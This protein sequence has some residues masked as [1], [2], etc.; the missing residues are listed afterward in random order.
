MS[1]ED[2][3]A[4]LQKKHQ[5]LFNKHKNSESELQLAQKNLLSSHKQN[6]YYVEEVSQHY[7]TVVSVILYIV[8]LLK[9]AIINY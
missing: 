6:K 1:L 5:A 2:S 8:V 4:H 9:R 7:Y 3:L